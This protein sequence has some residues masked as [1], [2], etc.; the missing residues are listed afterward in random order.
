MGIDDKELK[1]MNSPLKGLMQKHIEFRIFKT[2]LSSLNVDLT[3]KVILEVGC[4]SGYG[5]EL[6]TKKFQPTELVAFDILPELVERARQRR[7]PVKLFV[8]NAT[9]IK[10]PSDKFDA[11]FIFTVIHHVEGWHQVLKEVNRVLKHGG[12]LLVNELNRKSLDRIERFLKIKHPKKSRFD[13]GDFQEGLIAAGFMI[14]REKRILNDFG[15]F[16]CIKVKS[17]STRVK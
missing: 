12:I 17:P 16:I 6:I 1:F 11:V 3:G 9:D 5:I 10:L 13:W 15:F 7:L 2:L 4:G 14:L 8:G